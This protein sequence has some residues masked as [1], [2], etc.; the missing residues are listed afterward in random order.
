[1]LNRER[2]SFKTVF[3][4]GTKAGT[5]GFRTDAKHQ[6]SRVSKT[7]AL[8]INFKKNMGLRLSKKWIH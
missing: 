1:M 4:F 6:K 5:I 3:L 8:E 2:Q 7:T